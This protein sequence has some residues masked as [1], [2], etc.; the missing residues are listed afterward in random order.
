MTSERESNRLPLRAG[1][2]LL[3]AVAVVF[4]GLGAH[5]LATGSGDDAEPAPTA[6]TTAQQNPAPASGESKAAAPSADASST[7]VC[8]VNAGNVSGLAGSVTDQLK[9]KGYQT[10]EPDNLSSSTLSENTIFYRAGDEAAANQIATDLGGGYS[11]EQRSPN[12]TR[13]P[14]CTGGVLVIAVTE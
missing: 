7:K 5:S 12:Q 1:A 9:T 14:A 2:M 13:L 3:L 6:Q 4:F 8:V 11:V 10:A